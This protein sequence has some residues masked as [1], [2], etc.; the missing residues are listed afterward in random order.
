MRGRAG[1]V[2][3][4][5]IVLLAASAA[6][7][8]MLSRASVSSAGAQGTGRSGKPA[9]SA[10][11]RWVGFISTAPDL[12][13]GDGDALI[14]VFVRDR[15]TGPTTLVSKS[16]AGVKGNGDSGY[17]FN[18]GAV[19]ALSATGRY[20]AFT[21]SA[22]NL[23]L[24]AGGVF[25]HDRDAD[26]DGIFDEPG[27]VAT[28]RVS[29]SSSGI[30]GDGWSAGPAISNDGRVVAFFSSSTNLVTGDTNGGIDVFVHDRD[31]DGNGVFD[32][33][34]AIS[35]RRVSV[36]PG[37]VE[38][39]GWSFDGDSPSISANGRIIAFTSE[40]TNLVP[41]DTNNA[42]DVFAH[43]RVTGTTE[44]VNVSSSGAQTQ[45]LD[46][47][48][49]G[50]S[51]DGR[52]V[53]FTAADP[54]LALPSGYEP[55]YYDVFVRDR[56][57]GVTTTWTSTAPIGIRTGGSPFAPRLSADGRLVAFVVRF[58]DFY[59]EPGEAFIYVHDRV[60]DTTTAFSIGD[61]D[62]FRHAESREFALSA[63][64][65]A[66]AFESV[67]A[68]FVAG[69]T[70]GVADAFVHDCP[71]PVAGQT[72]FCEP[73]PLAPLDGTSQA[74]FAAGADEFAVTET[75]ATGLGP[76]FNDVS[77]A[78]CH[79]RPH[80][81]GS[82]LRT[83]TRIGRDGP[84][85][86]DDLA[87][88]GGPVIQE[89]GT[90]VGGCVVP[91]E[92]VPPEA[93]IV[94]RR[95]TPALFGLGL[96][97]R[98]PD[99]AILRYADPDDRNR[100]G[101]SGRP[102]LVG[103]R[104]GRFGRKAQIAS[105]AEFSADAYLTEMGVTSPSRPSELRPQGLDPVC[106]VASDPEDGGGAVAKFT[107][108]I[109]FLAPLQPGYAARQVKRAARPGARL[110]RSIGC[111]SCHT[112][113]FKALTAGPSGRR[114]NVVLWSD[115]LLHDMG[116][117]LADGIVQGDAS[118]SEFRT[119]PLWGVFWSAPYLHDG[120]ATTLEAAIVLHGGEATFA[121]DAFIALPPALR[122]QVVAFVKTL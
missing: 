40:A 12:T 63:D 5:V 7:A 11:G 36:G 98:L 27:A 4:C 77:C 58:G 24:G 102:N 55:G 65:R 51:A 38:G 96:V 31:T 69:D 93:T 80:T 107:D 120:R 88:L 35:T 81:G 89:Q 119:A 60:D 56:L 121:R 1:R 70:N 22:T 111:Q 18:N 59:N 37:G 105:L 115:L 34:G 28:V 116:A 76:V 97:D 71:Q 23:V 45:Y 15:R 95:D 43:D 33:P 94:A 78:A 47:F 112:S 108:F 101:I 72:S 122:A 8:G 6:R 91:G 48:N 29:V 13:P 30:A 49:S 61:G 53:A 85:G 54:Q 103:G 20:V 106:D 16:S 87:A 100:D 64:G 50:L 2:A 17:F 110:F 73:M 52:F 82:S 67:G 109:T 74:R 84:G 25:V 42:R 68:S 118:G 104:V 21:S 10:D 57:T 39:D 44:R 83:V 14:D 3:T 86:F 66:I 114:V 62:D 117:G 46:S 26:G 113:R 32:E 9:V 19:P 75:P 90:S 79:N 99:S 41:N 92:V